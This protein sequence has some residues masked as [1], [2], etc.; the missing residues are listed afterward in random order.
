MGTWAAWL[1]ANCLAID[2]DCHVPLSEHTLQLV[3]IE[4]LRRAA[5][6]TAAELEQVEEENGA[7]RE[8]AAGLQRELRLQRRAARRAQAAAEST[9]QQRVAELEQRLAQMEQQAQQADG[10]QLCS[11]LQHMQLD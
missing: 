9:L 2:K 6:A 1:R 11:T 8:R 7:L 10:P 4:R 3:M 5:H